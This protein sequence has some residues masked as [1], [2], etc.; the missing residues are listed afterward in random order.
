MSEETE[1]TETV[2]TTVQTNSSDKPIVEKTNDGYKLDFSKTKQDNDAVQEQSTDESLLGDIQQGEE[3]KQDPKMGLQEVVEEDKQ[4]TVLEEIT[5]TSVEEPTQKVEVTQEQ[6][7]QIN[8]E[9]DNNPGLELPENIQDLVKFM[10]ETGGSL[11]DYV[12]LNADYSN[13]DDKALLKEYYKSKKK[14]LTDD[15]INFLIEDKFA[16]DEDVDEEVDI[17]RKKLAFKEEVGNAREFLD[18]L[19]DE[20]YKEVKLGSKLLPEQQKAIEFFNRYNE[21]QK[22]ADKLASTQKERFEQETNKVFNDEFK[23]FEFK[24]GEKK[25]RYNV[26]DINSVREQQSDLLNVFGKYIEN[27]VLTNGRDYH[28][29]LFAANNPDALANHFY[30]QGKADAIRETTM[31]AKNINMDSRKTD[32]SVINANGT[33]VRVV[34]GDNSSK[35]K[36]KLKNY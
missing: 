28:K 16:F 19:K 18:G 3:T 32:Q 30:E 15:E 34:D 9:L 35:L 1:K 17:K 31:Q 21:Q 8:E 7:E 26:K 12:R 24:V 14:N 6:V 20:Y 25:Y 5:D 33:K 11:E 27:N 2:E 36:I 29:A 22:E 4:E 23:G 10:N 13:V